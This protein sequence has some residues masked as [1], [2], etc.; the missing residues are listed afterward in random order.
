MPILQLPI[1]MI[2]KTGLLSKIASKASDTEGVPLQKQSIHIQRII[3]QLLRMIIRRQTK[4]RYHRKEKRF[5]C[6]CF[7][8]KYR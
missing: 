2:L 7:S 8:S 4:R 3:N 6:P 1:Y 5:V